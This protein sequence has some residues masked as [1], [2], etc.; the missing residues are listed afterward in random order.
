MFYIKIGLI[1]CVIRYFLCFL[2][3]KFG[4]VESELKELYICEVKF[5]EIWNF[6]VESLYL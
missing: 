1:F 5:L 3:F 4:K 2:N 6:E